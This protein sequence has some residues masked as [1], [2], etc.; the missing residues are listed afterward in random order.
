MNVKFKLYLMEKCYK[1]KEFNGF[2][3]HLKLLFINYLELPPIVYILAKLLVQWR[4]WRN[5]YFL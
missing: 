5:V 2:K 4:K 1:L 3:V